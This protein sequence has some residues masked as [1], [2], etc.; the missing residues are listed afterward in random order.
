MD[1]PICR[2]ELGQFSL[3]YEDLPVKETTKQPVDN[4]IYRSRF[5]TRVWIYHAANDKWDSFVPA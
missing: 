3:E 4:G 2:L 5:D 1:D